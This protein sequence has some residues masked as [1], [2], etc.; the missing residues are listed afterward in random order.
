MPSAGGGGRVTRY[1]LHG[2][3][4]SSHQQIARLAR[5]HAKSPL[6]DVGAAQGIFG[7]L[8]ASSGLVMDAIE[9]HPTWAAAARP[10]YRTLYQSTIDQADLPT[11]V[12]RT[13][14]CGDVIEHTADPVAALRRL[15]AA[16]TC[17]ALF[18]VSVP[19]VAHLA[20]RL[21]LLCGRF[22]RME[23]GI[24]DR[25]HLQFFTRDSATGLLRDAGLRVE[26]VHTTGVPLEELWPGQ[27]FRTLY[28]VLSR[29]QRIALTLAPRVF[30]YQWIFVARPA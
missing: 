10:Y 16:A 4:G 14:V 6:L 24:L 15:R 11:G 17:D 1:R 2:D 5:E 20:V 30:A 29:L 25:T 26:R 13:V 28:G 8:L 18:I 3:P 22:P 27:R 23:R 9:P 12:Y 7:Q 19:N 21:L